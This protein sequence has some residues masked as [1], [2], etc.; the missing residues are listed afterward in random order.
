M[1][2]ELTPTITKLNWKGIIANSTNRNVWNQKWTIFDYGRF[3]IEF[4]MSEIYIRNNQ[5]CCRLS[6]ILYDL[7]KNNERTES[8]EY[9]TYDYSTMGINMA[10]ENFNEYVLNNSLLSHCLEAIDN[11]ARR[12]VGNSNQCEIFNNADNEN[13]YN[14]KKI[15]TEFL[16]KHDITN[17]K[18]RKAYI[19]AYQEQMATHFASEYLE[20]TYPTLFTEERVALCLFL[21]DEKRVEKIRGLKKCNLVKLR[22]DIKKC[23]SDKNIEEM[24]LKLEDINETE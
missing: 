10:P 23:L 18:M 14:A 8:T 12:K 15:A 16:D 5:L 22:T 4:S 3:K 6:P 13:S 7:D 11:V 9:S 24:K 2:N 19:S 17:E 20:K 21:G 1:K